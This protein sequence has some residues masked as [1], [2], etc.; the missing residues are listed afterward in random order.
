MGLLAGVSYDPAVAA[1]YAVHALS[2]MT[3]LDTTNLRVTFTAPS[4]GNVQVRLRAPMHGS[5]TMSQILLGVLE[6]STVVAR[7]VGM[8]GQ[9]TTVATARNVLEATFVVTG[10]TAGS[11]TWDA[12][13]AVQVV[14][15]SA[16]CNLRAGGPDNAT[17]NDA[18][19][20]IAFEVW[21]A[22]NLLAGTLYDPATA[23]SKATSALL[24]MTAFDT[25]NLRLTFTSPA[26][27]NVLV[28]IRV[29]F[30]G[31]ATACSPLL[32]VLDGATV[33]ARA[34][35]MIGKNYSTTPLTTTNFPCELVALVTGLTPNTSFTWDAAY[36]VEIATASTNFKYGGPN[37]AVGADAWGGAAYEIWA[38]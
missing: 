26:S 6:G 19:G 15:G 31:S 17:A 3:A 9:M 16:A 32:G 24:A 36:G 30:T 33:R 23:A 1:T 28:K 38:A 7:Q 13:A 22:A 29:P 14:D 12:A 18:F 8:Y 25:T 21:D 5:T 20:A 2:A 34:A 10:V 35:V 11:H 27:G 4:S 37:D